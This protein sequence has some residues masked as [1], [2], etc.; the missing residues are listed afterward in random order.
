MATQQSFL[1]PST[2]FTIACVAFSVLA[3]STAWRNNQSPVPANAKLSNPRVRVSSRPQPRRR[4]AA[5]SIYVESG[6]AV[7]ASLDSPQRGEPSRASPIAVLSLLVQT[8]SDLA[9]QLRS[10]QH[11]TSARIVVTSLLS[12]LSLLTT[13]LCRLQHVVANDAVQSFSGEAGRSACFAATTS[14]L[15]DILALLSAELES[16]HSDTDVFREALQQLR[17]Q[18]PALDFL[19]ESNSAMSLPP[20][21]ACEAT[22][23]ASLK[24]GGMPSSGLMP[25]PSLSTGFTPSIDARGQWVEPPP[26]YSPPSH[27]SLMSPLPEKADSKLPEPTA[28]EEQPKTENE[29]YDT[30]ALFNAV[31][32]NDTQA[33]IDLLSYGA[34]PNTVIGD[35]QRTALHQAA[36]LNNT[37]S[38][39]AILGGKG[40]LL[41]I[42]DGRGDT[43]LHLAAWAGHVEALSILL[44]HGAEIDF[45]SGRDGYSALWCSISASQID[46]AR[47]LL[48]H[49]ARVSLRSG[50]GLLP[51]HQAAVTGQSA[52][53][54]LLLERGAQVDGVDDEG[55]TAL[56][57]A[58]TCGSRATIEVLLRGGADVT[59][60]QAQGLTAGHW[61][62]HKGHTDVL[63]LLLMH[64]API[65]A[66]AEE[67]ATPLHLAASRG[68]DAAVKLLLMEGADRTIKAVWCGDEGPAAYMARRKGHV[69]VAEL[70]ASFTKRQ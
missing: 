69:R 54:E 35:L 2:Y 14:S 41:T 59:A 4:K 45:L 58:A 60:V 66:G 38:L 53:S 56:H 49:G 9:K 64:G 55:N 33:V 43:P 70:I 27:D 1:N 28:P 62:A 18:R 24:A 3:A 29:V 23:E 32:A 51:L 42:E 36:H 13:T 26:E 15:N 68:H 12:E 6:D 31:T 57:Y 8:C 48:R 17:D 40:A 61:A 47:L 22:I 67:G 11:L 39:S 44:T 21:P 52:I 20:T 7:Y 10:S 25:P 37:K 34:D 19:L 46:A 30:D 65:N 16:P 5:D 50:G 63:S